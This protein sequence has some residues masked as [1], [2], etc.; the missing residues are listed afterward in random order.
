MVLSLALTNGKLDNYVKHASPIY[1]NLIEPAFEDCQP[2]V[3]RLNMK[4]TFVLW[5]TAEQQW[6]KRYGNN[7]L[8]IIIITILSTILFTL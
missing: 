2:T 5:L 8:F 4:K 6:Y 7:K 3:Q 1:F